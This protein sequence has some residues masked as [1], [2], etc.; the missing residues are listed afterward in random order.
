M[1]IE[2]SGRDARDRMKS[3]ERTEFV[4][5]TVEMRLSAPRIVDS[6]IATTD[7]VEAKKIE[8]IAGLDSA[9]EHRVVKRTA[10]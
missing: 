8:Q 10:E 7:S 6:R 3:V 2:M 4:G 9:E 5:C 1:C